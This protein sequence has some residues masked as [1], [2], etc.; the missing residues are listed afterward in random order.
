MAFLTKINHDFLEP[1]TNVLAAAISVIAVSSSA[2]VLNYYGF[3]D[4]L[5]ESPPP[6]PKKKQDHLEIIKYLV[7]ECKNVDI[8]AEQGFRWACANGHLEI[9]NYL[10]D[11]KNDHLNIHDGSDESLRDSSCLSR[12]DDDAPSGQ[13]ESRRA[14]R[15]TLSCEATDDDI[16]GYR[17]LQLLSSSQPSSCSTIEE[18]KEYE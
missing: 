18:D 9:V 2:L 7:E 1:N 10:L 16:I 4:K 15:R 5:F 6:P 3:F 17:H 11:K 12:S 8:H 13:E 14:V